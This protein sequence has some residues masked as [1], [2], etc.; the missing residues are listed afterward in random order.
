[1]TLYDQPHQAVELH[2]LS[3]HSIEEIAAAVYAL[4]EEGGYL[5]VYSFLEVLRQLQFF[6]FAELAESWQWHTSAP[7]P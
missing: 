5:T 2:Y 1:V 4:H 3:A 7:A 6:E